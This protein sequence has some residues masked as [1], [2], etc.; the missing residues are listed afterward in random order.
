M[1]LGRAVRAAHWPSRLAAGWG[2][3]TSSCPRPGA[4]P[5][6]SVPETLTGCGKPRCAFYN[7]TISPVY[8][9]NHFAAVFPSPHRICP[10]ALSPPRGPRPRGPQGFGTPTGHTPGQGRAGHPGFSVQEKDARSDPSLVNNV[11]VKRRCLLFFGD[12]FPSVA[13]A[14]CVVSELESDAATESR[15]LDSSRRR[16]GRKV[17]WG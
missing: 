17:L 6:P 5:P 10:G 12:S 16:L 14:S 3:G 13:A 4:V 11:G 15:P 7:A 8:F 9:Q 1:D 2:L